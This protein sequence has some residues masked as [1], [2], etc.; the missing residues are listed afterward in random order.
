MR[1]ILVHEGHGALRLAAADG[2]EELQRQAHVDRHK[3]VGG[4][5]HHRDGREQDRVE[6]GLLPRLQHVDAGD[7][8]VLVVKPSQVLHQ[9][10]EC[11]SAGWIKED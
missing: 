11:H 2:G 9:V 3:D 6:D 10:L 4:V 8:K 5:D 1:A 7:Q